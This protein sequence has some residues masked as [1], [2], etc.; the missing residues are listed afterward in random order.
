MTTVTSTTRAT[1]PRQPRAS[2]TRARTHITPTT[3]RNRAAATPTANGIRRAL[4]PT[5]SSPAELAA[6]WAMTPSERVNAMWRGDLTLA[7]LTRWSSRRPT[8]VPLIAGEFAWIMIR[9]P[10]WAE[11]D[12][13][14]S[15]TPGAEGTP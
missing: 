5:P 11:A 7:Q 12:R 1:R 8:E 10:A 4:A 2:H 15:T 9:T 6:L 14:A 3:R 13:A